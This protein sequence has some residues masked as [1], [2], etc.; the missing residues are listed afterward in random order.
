MRIAF[1]GTPE[2]TLPTLEA[3]A[4]SGE[5]VLV[6]AQPDRPVGRSGRPQSPPSVKWAHEHGVRVEQPEKVKQGRLAALLASAQPDVAVVAAY[7][8]I[9]PPDALVAP[10]N[11]CLN[12]HASLLP[13]LRGA[14]PAQW[15]IAR[16]YRKTGVTI[17]QMDE[18]LDTGEIRLQREVPIAPDET[19]ESLLGKLSVVGAQA[20]TEALQLLENGKLSRKAQDHSK[21][22][23]APM[24]T[25]DD[26]RVDFGRT[27][28]EC[29]QRRRGF[30]PWPGAWTTL[31]GGVLKI[32]AAEPIL[33]SAN[34]PFGEIVKLTQDGVYVACAGSVWRL[35]ELQLEGKKRLAAGPFLAGTRLQVG[36][37]L[38]T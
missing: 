28:H 4:R 9:L 11:G 32:H 31:G 15:A 34:Q 17:M 36:D 35:V 13:E 27:A 14:A 6:V 19:G 30:T 25:R 38:G 22:T 18:G 24:L 10:R 3:C 37:R 2:F 33:Q 29:D 20:L 7:G 12:V 8:R 16:G 26:G 5:L 1:L 21:A 23:L